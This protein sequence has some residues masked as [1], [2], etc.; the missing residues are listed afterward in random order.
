MPAVSRLA[1]RPLRWPALALLVCMGLLLV[2]AAAN[3]ASLA[4]VRNGQVFLVKPDGSGE[5][6]V[7]VS[8]GFNS[9][10]QSDDGT[11]A[12]VATDGTIHRFDR[13]GKA[14]NPPFRLD[15]TPLDPDLSPDGTKIAFWYV[16]G[17]ER[18]GMIDSHAATSERKYGTNNGWYMSWIRNDRAIFSFAGYVRTKG[19]D[20][21]TDRWSGDPDGKR[22]GVALT[23]AGDILAAVI[24][25]FDGGSF[26]LHWYTTN[27]P[28]PED[29]SIVLDDPPGPAPTHRCSQDFGGTEPQ[30]LSFSP[31]GTRLAYQTAEGVHV[32]PTMNLDTCT[33]PGGGFNIPGARSPDFGPADVPTNGT[34][35]NGGGGGPLTSASVVRG[36][37]LRRAL[38]R[39][40]RVRFVCS[41]ACAAGGQVRFL[42][43][44]VATVKPKFSQSG[45]GTLVFRFTARGRRALRNMRRVR[46]TLV[47]GGADPQQ[48]YNEVRRRVTLRR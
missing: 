9:I 7:P 40:L 48:A 45:R 20:D 10:T 4:F 35:T 25:P 36:Q 43:S 29:D 13:G 21:E 18:I 41:R 15:V 31:D 47:L 46:L 24:A 6:R 3:A 19:L 16:T 2:P 11:L 42:N 1:S 27:G 39:G 8:A 30:H 5:H 38:R 28:P 12:G 17:E 23:R 26:T 14:L 32:I 22:Y 33:L 44:T 34:T 37:R